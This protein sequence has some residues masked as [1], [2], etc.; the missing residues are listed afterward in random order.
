MLC[1]HEAPARAS[2]TGCVP[3]SLRRDAY[4]GLV[5]RKKDVFVSLLGPPRIERGRGSVH[6]DTR[7][8]IALLAFLAMARRPAARDEVAA[9]LWPDSDQVRA[10][11]ALRRTLSS[12][13]AALGDTG[14]RSDGD[15][16]SLDGGVLVDV[17]RFRACVTEGRL[18]EAVDLYRGD[19][20]SGFSIK[21]SAEFDE[22]QLATASALNREF[23][24]VLSRLVRESDTDDAIAYARRWVEVDALEEEAHRALIRLHTRKGDRAAAVRQYKE[25]VAVLE[26][27]LGV[28]P[29]AETRQ[30]YEAVHAESGPR[31]E[32]N[33]HELM[34]DLLTLQGRYGEAERSYG[35]ALEMGA[36]RG[37]V[38]GKIAGVMQRRG[39][40]EAADDGYADA[41]AALGPDD[42]ADRAMLLADRSLNASR[43]RRPDDADAFARE[44]LD[45][46]VAS[47]D[48]RARAQAHN[49][50]G[51]LASHR[52]DHDAARTHLEASLQGAE[53][54][55]DPVAMAAAMN[56][57]AAALRATHLDQAL[58]L[59]QRALELCARVGDRHREAAMH[60]NLADLLRAAERTS[61]AERHLRLSAAIFAEIGEP[62]E[63]R[64]EIWKL[65]EW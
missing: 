27:H 55:A 40:Y 38:L 19:F 16:L 49:V 21:D 60:S 35:R 36:A 4:R 18:S 59:A 13:N 51:I 23:S 22:W 7:K 57:L 6:V 62:D 45:A 41:L 52:G 63:L 34:G 32:A 64:P 65:T 14:V 31:P 9:L 43:L 58:D 39:D 17:G 44:A 61:E 42:H 33:L 37:V 29:T 15:T 3:E 24:E 25:C 56:N 26:R 2:S 12:L 10:R 46:A 8:A 50:A 48:E 5:A 28:E 1:A 54:L 53:K 47:T 20:M 11:S 30:L